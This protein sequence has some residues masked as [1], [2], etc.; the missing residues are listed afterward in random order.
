MS[1]LLQFI[2]DLVAEFVDQLRELAGLIR[3]VPVLRMRYGRLKCELRMQV[4]SFLLAMFNF[5]TASAWI[6]VRFYFA[7]VGDVQADRHF[8]S[9]TAGLAPIW[10]LCWLVSSMLMLGSLEGC[11]RITWYGLS[12][13]MINAIPIALVAI[14][15]VASFW[16]FSQQQ[17]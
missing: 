11:R 10:G 2:R 17:S 4:I 1:E 13:V 6:N 15:A 12:A 8:V 7:L 14:I 3:W 16:K 5:C 9:M